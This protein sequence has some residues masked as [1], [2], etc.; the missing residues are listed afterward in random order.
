[1]KVNH[2]QRIL[3]VIVTQSDKLCDMDHRWQQSVKFKSIMVYSSPYSYSHFL[4]EG[5][6]KS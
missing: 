6:G 2:L 4:K 3:S 1:M 5:E